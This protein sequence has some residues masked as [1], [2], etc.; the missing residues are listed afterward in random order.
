MP[1]HFNRLLPRLFS[2]DGVNVMQLSMVGQKQSALLLAEG[3]FQAKV[4]DFSFFPFD[5]VF[6]Q[7][8]EQIARVKQLSDAYHLRFA[9][10]DVMVAYLLEVTRTI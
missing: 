6:E 1:D 5:P 3:G 7:N 4:V 8:K 9:D 2:D 10:D